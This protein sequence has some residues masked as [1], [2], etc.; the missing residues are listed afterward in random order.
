M[1]SDLLLTNCQIVDPFGP[2]KSVEHGFITIKDGLIES[3]G[4]GDPDPSDGE[5]VDLTGCLVLPGLINAHTHLYSALALGMPGPEQTPVTF[6]ETLEQIWWRLDRALDE[7][8]TRASFESGLLACLRAGV[9][10]V[11]DHHSSPSFV[12]GSLDILAEVAESLGM[13]VAVAFEASDRNGPDTFESSLEE[14]AEAIRKW[15]NHPHIKPLFGLH[16]SFTLSDESLEKVKDTLS[17]FPDV[18]IHI[19]LSE[20]PEDG[21]DAKKRGYLSPAERLDLFGLLTHQSIVVHGVHCDIEDRQL[22]F[23]RGVMLVHNPTSNA[24]NRVGLPAHDL[25]EDCAAGLGTDGMQADMLREAKEGTLI[26]SKSLSGAE[27]SPDLLAM[28]MR[29]NPQIATSLF[30]RP[31]GHIAEGQAADLAV[32][33]YDSRSPL[34]A[35]NAGSHL[36]F[37]MDQPPVHVI[38]HGQFRIRDGELI[39]LNEQTILA[40][41]REQSGRLWQSM[42]EL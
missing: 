33:P 38:S 13:D 9:T 15:S 3:A 24:N 41:S 16:A 36:L 28:L 34:S 32:Y 40:N 42:Q 37:G 23:D 31:I 10:T 35:E 11:I 27:A 5:T 17:E 22:L 8:S 29:N 30:S 6:L 20:G 18:G 7:Q 39:G 12:R 19:H 14:N 2:L 4:P 1:M 26:W 25:L 21:A